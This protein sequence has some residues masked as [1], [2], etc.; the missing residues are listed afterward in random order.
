[1]STN[2]TTATTEANK[3]GFVVLNEKNEGFITIEGKRYFIT[4]R[5]GTQDGAKFINVYAAFDKKEEESESKVKITATAKQIDLAKKLA[6]S[7]GVALPAEMTFEA[8]KA[9]ITE[10]I[11]LPDVKVKLAD[12]DAPTEGQMKLASSLAESLQIELPELTNQVAV[13]EFIKSCKA[14]QEQ[15]KQSTAA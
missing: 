14:L 4:L 5:E 10:S 1:M 7:K 6:K 11:K 3:L 8:Y 2:N 13:R 15:A 12:T 9:F